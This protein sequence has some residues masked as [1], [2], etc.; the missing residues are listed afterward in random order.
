MRIFIA[1]LFLIFSLQSWTKAD[2]IR[3]FEIE[4]ISI[5]D[6]LLDFFSEDE[7]KGTILKPYKSD[8]FSL[9]LSPK[10]SRSRFKTFDYIQVHFKTNDNKFIL[11][12]I[13]GYID[14]SKK[15]IEDCHKQM[16]EIVLELSEVF[17]NIYKSEKK[18][19]GHPDDEFGK[20]TDVVFEFKDGDMAIVECNDWT[21]GSGINDKLGVKLGT[22]EFINWINTEAY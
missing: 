2:D 19:T 21:E 12:T 14:Y 18:T 22:R 20:F 6:S 9:W 1:V 3:D 15:N 13:D 16:D 10:K 11:H 17:I 4:G 8:K 7:I 5:G